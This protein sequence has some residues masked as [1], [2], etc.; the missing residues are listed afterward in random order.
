MGIQTGANVKISIGTT[1]VATNETEYAAD[2]YVEIKGVESIGSFGDSSAEVS[3]TGL[4]DARTQ[5]LK[6]ARDAGNLSITMAFI[7]GDPGQEDLAA[8]EADDT[9]ANYNFKVEYADGEVRYL[10]GQVASLVEEVSGA[11]NVLMLT[12]EV[13]INKPIIRVA[14]A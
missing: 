6:G 4:G 11:N 3:F 10:A 7:G 12:S 8:A 14:A 2:A 1:T 13:R 5:K 9:S